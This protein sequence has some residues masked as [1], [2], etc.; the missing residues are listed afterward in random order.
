VQFPARELGRVT[1]R[2]VL[3]APRFSDRSNQAVSLGSELTETC[4]VAEAAHQC[5]IR[6]LLHNVSFSLEAKTE[7]GGC[8]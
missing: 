7:T 4:V 5:R 3:G 8:R 6:G 1:G 2:Q